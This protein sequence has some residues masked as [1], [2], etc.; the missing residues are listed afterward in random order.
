L[1]KKSLELDAPIWEKVADKLGKAT[2]KR[3]EVN[4]SRINRHAQENQIIVVPGVVLSSGE[5]K[6][7][8]NVAA[9]KFSGSASE[10]I[11]K[12]KGKTWTIEQLVK[13]NPK[14]SHVK[15]MV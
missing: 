14:G 8:V 3:V 7:P 15:I 11:H 12:A 10:K 13:E 9:W 1:K 5:M 4:L 2:R 6:K